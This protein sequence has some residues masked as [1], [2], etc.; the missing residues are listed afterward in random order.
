MPFIIKDY[1]ELKKHFEN[2]KPI[3]LKKVDK[4]TIEQLEQPRRDQVK[5]LIYTI[6]TLDKQMKKEIS[7]VNARPINSSKAQLVVDSKIKQIKLN[8]SLALYGAMMLISTMITESRYILQGSLLRDRLNLGMG[9]TAEQ[10][11]D[12]QQ[13]WRFYRALNLFLKRIY[14]KENPALGIAP[15]NPFRFLQVDV[16]EA[17][18]KRS[19]ELEES[20]CNALVTSFKA[21]DDSIVSANEF[22]THVELPDECT[23]PL[24]T[25]SKL[26]TALN[27]LTNTELGIKKVAD[28]PLL[29]NKARRTQLT[30][31]NCL[32][33]TLDAIPLISG[34]YNEDKIAILAGAMYM[35]RE[36]I[37][38]EYGKPCLSTDEIANSTVHTGLTEILH[39]NGAKPEVI[40]ALV[41][42]TNRFITY[43]TI[44]STKIR[45]SHMFSRIESFDLKGTLALTQS[46]IKSCRSKELTTALTAYKEELEAARKKD[47]PK[48]A[49]QSSLL[50][51]LMGG[52]AKLAFFS[53][54]T[55]PSTGTGVASTVE[56]DI[57]EE[58]EVVTH[59]ADLSKHVGTHR[60]MR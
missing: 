26:K 23:K 52:V 37:N 34:I 14:T 36:Q 32:A 28:I 50:S 11:P 22:S 48:D 6:E 8:G 4:E 12:E 47:H 45:S 35:V 24:G 17:I 56:A 16:L 2:T 46:I 54:P 31:L 25:W 60:K 44:Q 29:K 38:T 42:A 53:Q 18:I 10:T 43:M 57:E 15:D 21:D 51:S 27:D 33:E 30:F 7:A 9:I 5:F 20:S 19:Y 1:E 40:E 58:E 55:P 39:A 41:A 13:Y 3:Y 59:V 49:E